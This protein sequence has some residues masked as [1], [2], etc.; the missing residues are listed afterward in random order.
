MVENRKRRYSE[1]SSAVPS[2]LQ[3]EPVIEHGNTLDDDIIHLEMLYKLSI[4]TLK[5]VN[6]SQQR[7]LYGIAFFN[8]LFKHFQILDRF[9]D[10]KPLAHDKAAC[11]SMLYDDT[12]MYLDFNPFTIWFSHLI[13]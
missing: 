11:M 2:V 1:I 4:E 6:N 3:M 7:I 13:D 9:P 10:V 5:V 12:P 8:Y